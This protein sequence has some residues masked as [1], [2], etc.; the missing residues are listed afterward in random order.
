MKYLIFPTISG[1]DLSVAKNF[2]K[3][4][5]ASRVARGST[6]PPMKNL[7]Q[8]PRFKNSTT[9]AFSRNT[10]RVFPDRNP[11]FSFGLRLNICF[12]FYYILSVKKVTFYVE[13]FQKKKIKIFD[14]HDWQQFLGDTNKMAKQH[15]QIEKSYSTP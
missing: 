12:S 8:P 11:K 5:R 6:P 9:Q 13:D 10:K 4:R 2:H 1:Q 15:A 7:Q 14:S 3:H